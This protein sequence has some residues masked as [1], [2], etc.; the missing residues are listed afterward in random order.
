M[1]RTDDLWRVNPESLLVGNRRVSALEKA[2][3]L[4]RVVVVPVAF[5]ERKKGVLSRVVGRLARLV[6]RG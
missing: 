1:R 4:N 2:A 3:E 6:R 5:R